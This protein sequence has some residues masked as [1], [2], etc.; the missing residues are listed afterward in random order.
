VQESVGPKEWIRIWENW[1]AALRLSR[2]QSV[3]P[4]RC[5]TEPLCGSSVGQLRASHLVDV[6]GAVPPAAPWV[7]GAFSA[8]V[9]IHCEGDA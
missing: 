6:A 2:G 3:Q 1:N 8:R 4:L 7:Y 9:S 5:A